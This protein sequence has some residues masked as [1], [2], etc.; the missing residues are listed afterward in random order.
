MNPTINA[1]T[2]RLRRVVYRHTAGPYPGLRQIVGLMTP[3]GVQFLHTNPP[4]GRAFGPDGKGDRLE[5]IPMWPD[6]RLSAGLRLKTTDRWVMYQ[7]SP[8]EVAA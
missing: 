1:T 7:E 6:G 4:F 3:E 2:P 5:P 8:L